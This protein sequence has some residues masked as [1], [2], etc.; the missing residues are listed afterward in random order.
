MEF[1]IL[2]ETKNRLV[3]QLKDETHTFCNILKEELTQV[4]GVTTA[5]YRIDHPLIGI[6]QF[7]VE[8]KDLEP[9][10]AI[11]EALKSLKKKTEEFQTEVKGL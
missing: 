4:K 3:F 8:T 7:I 1:I 6:P 9:R 11:K 5:A 2:E 10:K